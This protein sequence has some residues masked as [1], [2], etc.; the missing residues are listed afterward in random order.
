MVSKK[1]VRTLVS[2]SHPTVLFHTPSP[3][4]VKALSAVSIDLTACAKIRKN[5]SFHK[6]VSDF[7][8]LHSLP[9]ATSM[10]RVAAKFRLF[11]QLLDRK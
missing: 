11:V 3:P 2:H 5:K 4:M 9:H 7:V 1:A 10:A 6:I 8:A